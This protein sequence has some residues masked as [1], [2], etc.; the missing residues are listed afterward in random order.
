M[1]YLRY[2]LSLFVT[3]LFSVLLTAQPSKSTWL[4]TNIGLNSDWILNQNAYGNQEMDYGVKLGLNANLG[5][6]YYMN[7]EYGFSTGVG[8][9]NLGQNYQGDQGGAKATRKVNLNYIQVPVFAMKQLCDPQHPCWLTFGPQLMFLTTGKQNFTREEGSALP[10][11][12]Y[13]PEGKIDV[14][15]W[16]KPFDLMLNLGFTN[17]Y[18]VRTNDKMRMMLSFNAAISVLDINAKAYQIPNLR[19][20]YSASRNFYIGAQFG[21]MFKP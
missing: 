7:T 4:T 3:I 18:Y 9:S 19:D 15:K 14:T 1:N 13:L 16:Y 8:I 6:N 21:L 10:N 2:S 12:E 20:E 11:P 17:L 5:L